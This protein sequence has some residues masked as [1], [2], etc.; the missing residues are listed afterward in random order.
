MTFIPTQDDLVALSQALTDATDN[1]LRII[2]E[3]RFLG[4]VRDAHLNLVDYR[5]LAHR[6]NHA[7]YPNAYSAVVDVPDGPVI[8]RFHGRHGFLSNFHPSTVR[9]H[10][11]TWPTVEHAFQ[12][13]K[14][15]DTDE[16]DAIFAAATP[17]QA[18]RLG[19]R[20]TLRADWEQVK[21]D[22]MVTL[23]TRKFEQHPDLMLELIATGPA[24]L[25]E[26]NTWGDQVWG[27]TGENID[28]GAWRWVGENRLGRALMAVRRRALAEWGHS[29]TPVP[30]EWQAT[31]VLSLRETAG[32]LGVTVERV[33]ALVKHG[34]LDSRDGGVTWVS[35]SAEVRRRRA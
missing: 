19:R 29:H 25:V 11:P 23:V 27:A 32:Q 26:G 21:N 7:L 17:G 22:V 30:A 16:R 4:S 24:F 20:V 10:G 3:N 34:R 33:H 28:G 12:A 31:P 15:I 13:A 2:N 8:D 9:W 5:R 35:V 1:A 18:K 14:T 6:V